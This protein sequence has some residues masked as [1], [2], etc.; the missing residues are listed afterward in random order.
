M[1]QAAAL[2]LVSPMP[3]AP[4]SSPSNIES[5]DSRFSVAASAESAASLG[6]KPSPSAHAA[7]RE[8][9]GAAPA[10]SPL[11]TSSRAREGNVR[12][13]RNFLDDWNLEE[14]AP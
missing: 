13:L 6:E 12:G 3:T 5:S 10:R 2:A 1:T 9:I 4:E 11:E 14:R 8:A 7:R